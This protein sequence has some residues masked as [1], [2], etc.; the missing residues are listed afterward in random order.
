MYCQL[1]FR[2]GRSTELALLPQKDIILQSFE[3]NKLTIGIF[4]D[5]SK[6]FD[7]LNYHSLLLKL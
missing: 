2:K 7:S 4:V 3:D 6:A 5:F 1:G